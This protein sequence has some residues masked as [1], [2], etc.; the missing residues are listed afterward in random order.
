MAKFKGEPNLTVNCDLGTIQMR[1]DAEGFMS[2]SDDHPALPR[3]RNVFEE[4]IEPV[5]EEAPVEE[6]AAVPKK[7]AKKK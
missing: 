3:M 4:V 1:F 5:V 2:L 6:E 7:V